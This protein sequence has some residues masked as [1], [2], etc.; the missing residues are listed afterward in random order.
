ML[1]QRQKRPSVSA[2]ELQQIAGPIKQ[3]DYNFDFCL[4][5]LS[6]AGWGEI[7]ASAKSL[8]A[9]ML[10]IIISHCQNNVVDFYQGI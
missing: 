7:V 10:L 3:A 9:Q 5:V 6:N 8:A 1:A 2:T 4:K